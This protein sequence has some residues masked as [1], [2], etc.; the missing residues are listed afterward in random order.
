VSRDQINTTTG[1]PTPMTRTR[2]EVEN[3]AIFGSVEYDFAARWTAGIE[4]RWAEDEVTVTATPAPNA[5][6]STAALCNRTLCN[7]TSRSLTPRFT[8]SWR[9]TDD[10][11]TYANIAKGT[12]PG[13]FNS[14]VP[15]ESYRVVDEETLWSY[16]LGFRS[17]LLDD[18]LSLALAAYYLEVD[19]QQ[20][21]S[22]VEL[23]TG[24]T[25]SI[26]VNAGQTSARGIEAELQA[27][28][29][30]NLSMQAS[31]AWTDSEFDKYISPEQADLL[32]GDGSYADTQLL[33]DVSGKDS[34]RVPKHMASLAARYQHALTAGTQW[35]AA[36]D[37]SY[38]SS[39]Y[40]S[41]HNLIETGDRQLFGLQAGLQQDRWDASLWVRNLFDDDT[42]VDIFR[43]FDGRYGSLASFPQQGSSTPSRTP[44]GFAIPLAPGRQAGITVRV[45]F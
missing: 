39:R 2:D 32:G 31:Y 29:T 34:P 35:Y 11:T 12:K 42:P 3:H 17:R 28:L 5:P 9:T 18:R 25:E 14:T 1:A 26:L 24:R 13:D 6:P 20:L 44:R 37:W 7:D 10:F 8:L 19:D 21:T 23:D 15:D 45:K 43:Y 36:A 22:L 33:G 16:E 27:A 4:L 38:E 41:E 40:A 30:D